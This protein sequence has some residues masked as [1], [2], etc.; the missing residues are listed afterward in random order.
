MTNWSNYLYGNLFHRILLMRSRQYFMTSSTLINSTKNLINSTQKV[1]TVVR[2]MLL[3][4]LL[5]IRG[6]YISDCL[7]LQVKRH[8]LSKLVNVKMQS[9]R[10]E[11][12]R[13]LVLWHSKWRYL[14]GC[15]SV[16]V[17]KYVLIFTSVALN[18]RAG[19]FFWNLF[20]LFNES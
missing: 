7:P 9:E 13:H 6:P 20:S 1:E 17:I 14:I 15:F 10:S 16:N 3:L 5:E 19:H 2:P 4:Y 12:N 11:M 8:H 18:Y